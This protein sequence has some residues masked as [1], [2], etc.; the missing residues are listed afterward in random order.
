M[1][2]LEVPRSRKPS[3]L[4]R[5]IEQGRRCPKCYAKLKKEPVLWDPEHKVCPTPKCGYETEGGNENNE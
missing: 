3:F 5:D 2:L 4:S 1:R